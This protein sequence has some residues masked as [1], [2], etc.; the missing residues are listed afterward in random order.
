LT[1]AIRS[2]VYGFENSGSTTRFADSV[3]GSTFRGRTSDSDI[4]GS[5][6]DSLDFDWLMSSNSKGVVW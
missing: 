1:S 3:H 2:G 6:I 4:D 5:V